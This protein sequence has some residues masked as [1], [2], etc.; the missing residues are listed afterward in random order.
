MRNL[1]KEKRDRIILIA[2]GTCAVIAGLYYGIVGAQQKSLASARKMHAE[3]QN[4]LTN[5]ERLVSN[6]PQVQKGLE[7]TLE[8]L[9]GVE[10]TMASGDL[11]SWGILAINSFKENYD[12][13]IPQFS[14]EISAEVGM[15]PNF[16][17]KAAIFSLRGSAYYHDFGRFVADF[18]NSF[19]FMRIQNI[20]L[21]P[22][23]SS[24]ANGQDGS[25]KLS[26]KMEI[27]ALVNPNRGN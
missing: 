1:P 6:L 26:F 22:G 18:E 23:N 20:E 27:V 12:I 2:L 4:Q 16:P 25:E 17:Y 3:K 11:Y 5:A 9:R 21:D 10:S 24:I 7:E 14:R 15:F 19:P 13:D 8:H